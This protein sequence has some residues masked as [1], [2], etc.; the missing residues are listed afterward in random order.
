MIQEIKAYE[1]ECGIC[2]TR[3]ED[4]EFTFF[5]SKSDLVDNMTDYGWCI[6]G[7]ACICPD[8]HEETFEGDILIKINNNEIK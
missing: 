7:D 2:K 4:G 6:I 8:C 5:T 3:F 1:A